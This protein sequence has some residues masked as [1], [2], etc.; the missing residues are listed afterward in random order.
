MHCVL[1]TP[2]ALRNIGPARV[3]LDSERLLWLVHSLRLS[4][5]TEY[6]PDR[7][8]VYYISDF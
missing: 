8:I 2:P 6:I 5:P 3:L 1:F 7:G 4:V